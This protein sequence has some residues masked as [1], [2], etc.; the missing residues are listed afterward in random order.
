ME[1]KEIFATKEQA[2]SAAQA[3][4]KRTIKSNKTFRFSIAG[5]T[6]LFAES[7]I[8]LR[9]FNPKIPQKWIM[10]RVEHSLSSSGFTTSVDCFNGE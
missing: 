5:R 10:N 4:F 9:G 1:L 7:P 6:D 8:V 2:V 3:Q